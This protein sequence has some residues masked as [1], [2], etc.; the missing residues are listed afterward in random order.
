[1][2]TLV[3]I[4]VLVIVIVQNNDLKKENDLLKRNQ[5]KFCPKCGTSLI[6]NQTVQVNQPVQNQPV[7]S[8]P[9][10]VNQTAPVKKEVVQKPK[11]T[12]EEVKNN[13][14]LI[15]GS[16][17]IILA[18][19]I[20][21]TSSWMVTSNILKCIIIFILFFVFVLSSYLAKEKLKLNQTARAFKY[22]A[23]AYLPLS[24]ISL[25]LFSLLGEKFS[26]N[27]MY[28]NF[29]YAITFIL[30][31]I[32]YYLES[33]KDKDM[34]LSIAAIISSILGI[35]FFVKVFSNSLVILLIFLF[36]Y[37]YFLAMLYERH[38]YIYDEKFT[39]VTLN[40]LFY[41]L[42]SITGLVNIYALFETREVTT[43]ALQN[44]ALLLL[45][46]GFS[47][48]LEKDKISNYLIPI[49]I[50]LI[51]NSIRLIT[52]FDDIAKQLIMLMSVI[53]LYIISCLKDKKINTITFVLSTIVLANLFSES[54]IA[55]IDTY[56]P[57]YLLSFI[58]LLLL[59]ITYYLNDNYRKVLN[60]V[61]P[62][63]IELT[64][65]LLVIDKSFSINILL[66]VSVLLTTLPLLKEFKDKHMELVLIPS[67]LNIIYILIAYQDRSLISFAL[68]VL[69]IVTLYLL[70]LRNDK[71]YKYILYIFINLGM[72]YL[73]KIICDGLVSYTMA[74]SII[75]IIS[76]EVIEER[77]KD[78]GNFTYII[79][80]FIITALALTITDKRT[81]FIMTV[82]ISLV[83]ASYLFDNK[84]NK[85]YYNLSILAPFLYI[86]YSDV[87]V[88]NN[89]NC[90]IIIAIIISLVIPLLVMIDKDYMKLAWAP[91]VYLLGMINTEPYITIYVPLVIGIGISV[92]YYFNSDKKLLFKCLILLLSLIMYYHILND[93]YITLVV[94]TLGV[95]LIYSLIITRDILKPRTKDYKVFEYILFICINFLAITSFANE[96]DGMLYVILLVILTMIS[97]LRKYG[98]AFIVSIVFI[99]INMF[100]L[101]R[102][103]WLSLPWWIYILGVGLI[104][105]VFAIVNEIHEKNN[106]KENLI[107]LKNNLDL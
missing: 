100:L 99:L 19:V 71:N 78:K 48:Y 63:F 18:A 25:S 86:G 46:M 41:S 47:V 10:Q 89:I 69:S 24:L 95:L 2:I 84:M 53:V 57:L 40:I 30:C 51:F 31:S 4:I 15:T 88:F 66:A 97:Y 32:I 39:K 68:I 7:Q 12:E 29:Y 54:F 87:M 62:I 59:G 82:V 85:G 17:L 76:L 13:V 91:Y 3:L 70:S 11:M 5:K 56:I 50:L 34:F 38:Y 43:F 44:I 64:T 37:S 93:I 14:I 23:L 74:L 65:I 42:I 67:V 22:I 80:D 16:I 55:F 81:A 26:I 98:P 27:G 49:A 105:I 103:F 92:I 45:S 104:L 52:D 72:I 36:I 79:I 58:Y 20:Y 83:L 1:M 107:S 9:V 60:W 21:L 61:I 101:T 96:A 102:R 75:I 28:Q 90:M 73:G 8:S 94:F 106:F 77:F 6:D 33:K 35:I